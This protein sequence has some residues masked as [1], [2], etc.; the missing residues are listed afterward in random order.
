MLVGLRARGG[1]ARLVA[2]H[3]APEAGP[4]TYLPCPLGNVLNHD[5]NRPRR[6]Q[7]GRQVECMARASSRGGST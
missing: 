3:P 6:V 7:S 1:G 2:L 5:G 4:R